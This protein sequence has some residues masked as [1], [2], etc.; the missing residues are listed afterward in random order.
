MTEDVSYKIELE[1][2]RAVFPKPY[3]ILVGTENKDYW[4]IASTDVGTLAFPVGEEEEFE[5]SRVPGLI[6][7]DIL[8][9]GHV[10]GADPDTLE[11]F[12]KQWND[13]RLN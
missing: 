2:K 10:E 5:L 1:G 3:S 4:V 8:R 9:V 11:V 13:S 12:M 6:W 7:E